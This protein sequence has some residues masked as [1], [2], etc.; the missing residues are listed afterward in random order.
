MFYTQYCISTVYLQYD[1]PV[2]I[3]AL[4]LV[5][6]YYTYNNY[7]LPVLINVLYPVLY[8]STLPVI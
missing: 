4:Y 8:F 7:D 5:L 3:N 6:Y 1:L 2:L